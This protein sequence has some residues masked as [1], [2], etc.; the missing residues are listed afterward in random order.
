MKKRQKRNK[1]IT[2]IPIAF[3]A[4]PFMVKRIRSFKSGPSAMSK[5]ETGHFLIAREKI[6]FAIR[7]SARRRRTISLFID[8]TET[9]RVAAPKRASLAE[10]ERLMLRQTGWL[11]RRLDGIR[12]HREASAAFGNGD[13]V[14]YLGTTY[15]PRVVENRGQPQGCA[16]RDG[17]I[18][19]NLPDAPAD[20]IARQED[21]RLEIL[22]WYKKQAKRVFKER[23]DHWSEKLNLPYRRFA[24]SNPRR[25]WG[26]CSARNDVCLN[27][28]LILASLE[29]IDYVVVHEL[30]HVRHKHHGPRFWHLVESTMPDWKKLRKQLREFDPSLVL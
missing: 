13:H 25:L 11:Q 29:L 7:R 28:R 27:W 14:L 23:L 2:F 8:G 3:D 15:T 20:A 10:I 18:E 16:L 22:L 9:I 4:W 12:Q 21:M 24:V 1:R 26:S 17:M 6:P 5:S 30:C 19:I